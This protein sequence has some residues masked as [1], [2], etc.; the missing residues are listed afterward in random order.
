MAPDSD[1]EVKLKGDDGSESGYLKAVKVHPLTS[2][3][4]AERARMKAQKKE[5]ERQKQE[6][7]RKRRADEEERKKEEEEKKKA[8]ERAAAAAAARKQAEEEEERQARDMV[9]LGLRKDA[10][11]VTNEEGHG[12]GGRGG[13]E[14]ASPTRKLKRAATVQ[15]LRPP[16]LRARD[17]AF[18]A[19]KP[20]QPRANNDG[21]QSRSR[22]K[23]LSARKPTQTR[24]HGS[25]SRAQ[26][27]E[28]VESC[29]RRVR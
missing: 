29:V 21:N 18:S 7:E 6:A 23:S 9:T 5:A 22:K 2:S 24:S 28:S 12:D 1:A 3:E 4:A 15:A 14:V 16:Q 17:K 27:V 13:D 10:W 11:G 26:S 25:V 19:R 8:A 20:T